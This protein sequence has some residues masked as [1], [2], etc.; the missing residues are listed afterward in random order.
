MNINYIVLY[1][2]YMVYLVVIL[3]FS[4]FHDGHHQGKYMSSTYI[5]HVWA[6]LCTVLKTVNLKKLLIEK[7]ITKHLNHQ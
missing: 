7:E 2:V 3:K 5:L 6:S 4:K 1:A